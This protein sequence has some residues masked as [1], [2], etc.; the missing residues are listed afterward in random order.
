[1]LGTN[2]LTKHHHSAFFSGTAEIHMQP[3][4]DALASLPVLCIEEVLDSRSQQKEI[5][6]PYLHNPLEH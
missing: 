1:M 6:M 2:V 4:I 5:Y 3:S